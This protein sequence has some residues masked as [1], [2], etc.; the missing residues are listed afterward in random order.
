MGPLL[1]RIRDLLGALGRDSRRLRVSPGR[2]DADQTAVSRS[3][4]LDGTPLWTISVGETYGKP[5]RLETGKEDTMA[6]IIKRDPEQA[7]A[8]PRGAAWEPFQLMREMLNWDPFRALETFAPRTMSTWTPQFDVKETPDS[9]ILRADLPGIAE[10]NLEIQLTGNRLVVSGH[11]EQE[12]RQEGESYYAVERSYGTF[13][14]SF[15]LPDGV[16][17][18][19]IDAEMKHGVLTLTVPKREEVKPRKIAVKQ[20]LADKVK[21]RLSTGNKDKGE[22]A[23]S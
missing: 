21:A 2:L 10:E 8:F 18:D 11:R 16:D 5:A 12:E 14:R 1:V 23:A 17:A 19:R 4:P 7:L 6:N 13:T 15:T 3:R 9:Y 20:S 22:T